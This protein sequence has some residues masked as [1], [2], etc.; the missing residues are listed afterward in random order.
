MRRAVSAIQ[1][2]DIEQRA[3]AIG[4]AMLML[5]Q[6]QGT[7]DFENGGP[8]PG[9]SNS[10]QPHSRQSAGIATAQFAGADAAADPLYVGSAGLLGGGGKQ[11][12]PQPT[13]PLIEA[14]R[15]ASA[16]RGRRSYRRMECIND[17]AH[18]SCCGVRTHASAVS[19]IGPQTHQSGSD[20]EL[21][22]LQQYRTKMMQSVRA[23]LDGR[24]Q[25]TTNR[26]VRE[27]LDCYRENLIQLGVNWRPCKHPR[28]SAASSLDSRRETP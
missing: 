21:R 14:A 20:E 4:H 6:L 3:T 25:K 7:L 23:R 19:S 18:W 16:Y 10:L 5:Q 28:W 8:S 9:S 24:L 1:T 17:S 2:S 13:H 12:K 22:A 11:L 15:R 27:A 26:D